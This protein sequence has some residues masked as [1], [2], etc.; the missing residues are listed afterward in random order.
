MKIRVTYTD[1]PST[2]KWRVP[3]PGS[4]A[5]RRAARR[6]KPEDADA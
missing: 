6:P 4:E 1:C 5:V 2:D 3:Q